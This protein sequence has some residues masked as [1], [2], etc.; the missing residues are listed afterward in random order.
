MH[1]ITITEKEN[2]IIVSAPYYPLWI[3][4]ANKLGG[5]WNKTYRGHEFPGTALRMSQILAS[6]QEIFGWNPQ[7]GYGNTFSARIVISEA[8]VPNPFCAC[9]H[10]IAQRETRDSTGRLDADAF[11]E[12]GKFNSY[13]GSVKYPL[14]GFEEGSTLVL[15]N[16]PEYFKD[17]LPAGFTEIVQ[18]STDV[19]IN[20]EIIM[21]MLHQVEI[22]VAQYKT[23]VSLG[24]IKISP[25]DFE[26]LKTV[27]KM[28]GKQLEDKNT[29]VS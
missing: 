12:N 11:F 14:C 23:A 5:K 3:Q 7:S 21:D 24:Q 10:L 6:L 28:I 29:L 13:G 22:T 15:E 8:K 27:E 25:I 1:P 2:N 20:Q 17:K 18:E 9:G 19:S 16:I 26:Y 4:S